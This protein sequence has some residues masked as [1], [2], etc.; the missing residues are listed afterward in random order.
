MGVIHRRWVA[1]ATLAVAAL[2]AGGCSGAAGNPRAVNL[3]AGAQTSGAAHTPSIA[4][5]TPTAATSSD[6]S[7]HGLAPADTTVFPSRGCGR[8]AAVH[9]VA[10]EV[11]PDGT[12]PDCII[13]SAL[14]RLR[15]VNATN[16][17]GVQPFAVEVTF[18]GEPV[19]RLAPGKTTTFD[20]AF[21]TFLA[22]GEHFLT[23][24]SAGPTAEGAIIWLK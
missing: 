21:G 5:Q 11:A 17:F 24:S 12:H 18:A 15:V 23:I 10:V 9:I 2:A 22:P 13:V 3:S 7:A 8:A 20:D 19:R 16:E 1:G 14:Q 6:R 4:V